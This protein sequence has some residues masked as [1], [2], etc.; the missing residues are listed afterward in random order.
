MFRNLQSGFATLAKLQKDQRNGTAFFVTDE[1]KRFGFQRMSRAATNQLGQFFRFV[2][3]KEVTAVTERL[4]CSV[5]Q[6]VGSAAVILTGKGSGL[7]FRS[8][9]K[10]RGI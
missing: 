4:R 7:T 3:K 6:F 9:G 10:I 8:A 5:H 2:D 1:G